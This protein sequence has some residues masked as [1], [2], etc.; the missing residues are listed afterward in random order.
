MKLLKPLFLICISLCF[1]KL[2]AQTPSFISD[3]LD[4]YITREMN[5]W[6]IPGLA[7]AIVKD[8]KVIVEKGYGVKQMH[9]KS[10]VDEYTLFQ[11]ASNSKAFTGTAIAWLHHEQ[12]LS[13][14]HQVKKYLPN[15]N[16]YDSVSGSLCTVRDLLCHRLGTQTFQGDFLNWGSNLSRMQI[17]EGLKRTKP[18]YPFRYKYG[19]NNAAFVTA[20]EIIKQVTDTT[21]DD[22]LS[23]RLFMPMGMTRTGTRFQQ[24]LTDK[25][26]CSPHTIYKGKLQPIPLC[27][28][29]NMSASAAIFSCVAD[30]K[31]WLLLQLQNGKHN[32]LQLVPESVI[33]ETRK[34]NMIA[35]DVNSKVFKS[36]HFVT[37]GLGWQLYDYHGRRVIEHSGGANGFVTKTEL[38]PEEQLGVIVYTNTDQNSLYDALCKQIIEAYLN[39]PYRNLSELYFNNSNA[40]QQYKMNQLKLLEDSIKSAKQMPLPA[41]EYCGKYKNELYGEIEIKLEKG[42]LIIYFSNHPHNKGKLEYIAEQRFMCYYTDITCGIEPAS[43]VVKENKIIGVKIKV[44]DFIDYITYDFEKT[45]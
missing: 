3:S 27:N 29:E 42:K 19:Y 18:V 20:G 5:R 10:P 6:Q 22:F 13:L 30:M 4:V 21:W 7:I 16:L 1:F 8:G 36:K 15:F 45:N 44:D 24:M 43:F 14:E 41:S 35:N 32:N 23:T 34:S 25:N 39:M 33:L 37:Y 12:K 28:I 31:Y 2:N 38:I 26:A 11:I 9:D 17:V 40:Q